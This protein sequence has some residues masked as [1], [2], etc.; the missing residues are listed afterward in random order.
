MGISKRYASLVIHNKVNG[1][2][3]LPNA[4]DLVGQHVKQGQILAYIV[5]NENI[6]VR[7]SIL[8]S[9]IGLLTNNISSIEMRTANNLTRSIDV[10]LKRIVPEASNKLPHAAL[11]TSGGGVISIDPQDKNGK[12]SLKKIFL[13]EIEIPIEQKN[14]FLGQR[15]YLRFYHGR[16]SLYRQLHRFTR[17]LFLRKLN[18]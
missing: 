7:A 17:Q 18:V 15:V 4:D 16:E 3:I 12:K 13:I 2:F 9:E 10:K 6:I 5:N 11:G 1:K 8:Q 14:I